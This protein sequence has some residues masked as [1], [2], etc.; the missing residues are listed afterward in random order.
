MNIEKI[1]KFKDGNC[2]HYGAIKAD[3]KRTELSRHQRTE[4]ES[5][6]SEIALRTAPNPIV[7]GLIRT[8]GVTTKAQEIKPVLSSDDQRRIDIARAV[9]LKA[10]VEL[11]SSSPDG[12]DD[13]G[14]LKT[15]EMYE[16]WLLRTS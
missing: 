2:V 5:C 9:A 11:A 8:T 10:A 13:T 6:M 15:A 7:P 12:W 3:G 1:V 4:S 14:I 16:K